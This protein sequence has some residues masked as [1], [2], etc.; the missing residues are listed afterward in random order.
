MIIT[1]LAF[2]V[3]WLQLAVFYTQPTTIADVVKAI[4]VTAII[5]LVLGLLVE[6]RPFYDKWHKP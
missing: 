4:L 1:G 3:T 2:L 6:G 5:F